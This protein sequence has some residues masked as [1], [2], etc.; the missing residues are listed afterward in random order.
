[1]MKSFKEISL[2][3]TEEE[4]RNDGKMH[5]S[6]LAKYERGGGFKSIPTL[7][8]RVESPS[9]LL[10]S[11][12]DCL[13]TGST[14]EFDANYLVVDFPSIGDKELLVVKKLFSTFGA[15]YPLL[16]D[17]PN[18]IVGAIIDEV[19]FQS[20]WKP[21]TR[22]KIIKERCGEYY[23]L[24]SIAEG[25]TIVSTDMY[26]DALKMVDALRTAPASRFLFAN[27]DSFNTNIERL[28]QLKFAADFDGISYS[29]MAD[30]IVVFHD[31]KLVLPV[32]LKTSS[33][34]EYEFY[35]SFLDW[36]YQIQA[37][38]YAKIIRSNM[39]KDDYFKNFKLLN[40]HFVVCNKKTLNPLVWECPFTFET[41]SIFVGKN[42]QIELRD[43]SVIA[44]ELKYY[45]DNPT[46]NV[47]VGINSQEPN[48]LQTW[49]DKI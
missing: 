21:E 37:R 33:H 39:D 3:I 41:G 28:Y 10:G 26:S 19:G 1:M 45:L 25:K 6:T 11:I 15:S 13:L 27:D 32:D 43:P 34:T 42:K 29:C 40:Y 5:Y 9:L 7:F 30:L 48:N 14:E 36:N 4:Y 2:D 23:R 24:L 49:L 31:K 12:V 47:P 22:I 16:D 46:V 35:Q 38:N 20:N 17:I 18:A 44:K 8:D